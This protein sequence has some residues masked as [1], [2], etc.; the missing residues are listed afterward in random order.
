[1]W[2]EEWTHQME[3]VGSRDHYAIVVETKN[4]A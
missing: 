3:N 1:M 2:H 4:G